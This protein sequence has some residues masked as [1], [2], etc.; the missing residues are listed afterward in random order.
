MAPEN[1]QPNIVKRKFNFFN[2]DVMPDNINIQLN[3]PK[4]TLNKEFWDESNQ[5]KKEIRLKMLKIAKAFN[6]YLKLGAKIKDIIFTGSMANYN[7]NSASDIDIHLILDYNSID[8]PEE[9][10]NEYISCKKSMFNDKYDIKIKGF[11][12][13]INAKDVEKK[14]TSKGVYS[15]GKNKW[16]INPEKQGGKI[17]EDAIKEKA[18]S[19]MNQIDLLK[20]IDNDEELVKKSEKLKEKIKKLRESGLEEGGEFSVEN[21]VL[22]TLKKNGYLDKLSAIKTKAVDDMLSL[23]ENYRADIEYGCLMLYFN[24]SNWDQITGII[25][26]DDIYEA[27]GFGKEKNPHITILYGFTNDNNMDDVIKS[28]KEE[29]GNNPIKICLTNISHFDS[30]DYDVVKF[31]IESSQLVKLN[32]VVGKFDHETTFPDYHPHMTISYVKPGLGKKYDKIFKKEICLQSDKLVYSGADGKKTVTHL[33]PKKE[34]VESV[35]K[36]SANIFWHGS[37][38]G[39]LRG[40]K[41]GLHIGTYDAA[42]QALEARIGVPAEGEWDGTR[43]YGKTKLAGEKTLLKKDPRGYLLTGYNCQSPQEDYY[44]SDRK[45]KAKY[46]D[47]TEVLSMVKPNIIPVKIKGRMTN[48]PN[49][50]HE[51][52]KANALMKGQIT[53]GNAKSGYYYKNDGEDVGSISAVVPNGEYVEKLTE[54]IKTSPKKLMTEYKEPVKQENTLAVEKNIEGMTPEKVEIIKKFINFTCNRLELKRPLEIYLHKGRD[55]YISTTA[56][57]VPDENTNHIRCEG[58]AIVDILRSIGHELTHMKQLEMGMYRVG[59]K[60]QTIGGLLEDQAN[61]IAG[62]LIKDFAM[63]FGF[64]KIYDL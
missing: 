5:L 6:D 27:D 4:S 35:D 47:G 54:N 33:N 62:I 23:N 41:Y 10:I 17:D 25:K 7:W 51:D 1:Q 22:K 50:P 18:V 40:G 43:E 29:I 15:V 59:D 30:K 2:E 56:A 9:F 64:D 20:Q 19:I 8:L 49:A 34:L 42:K 39:D 46:G 55:E 37:P 36:N 38:S 12:V 32:E 16:L 48:T 14:R 3:K 45:E 52:F 28:V 60:T 26:D 63:N 61:S 11:E 24:V 31:D 21:L 44:S 53:K 13:E 57:Y 58:R